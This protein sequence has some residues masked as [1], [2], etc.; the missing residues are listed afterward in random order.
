MI[1][2]ALDH[3][4]NI[5]VPGGTYTISQPI[6]WSS[7]NT[8]LIGAGRTSSIFNFNFVGTAGLL[9][10]TQG[11]TERY[12]CGAEGIQ[13]IDNAGLSRIVDLTDM[14]FCN[15]N[16]CFTYGFGASSSI[17][18]YMG[19]SNVSLQCT[20]NRIQD[21]YNG[22]T[23]YGMYLHDGANANFIDGG[24]FQ[25]ALASAIGIIL[26]PS[27]AALVN[28]NTLLQVGVEQPGNTLT[29]IQLNGN[30][31]GTQ[32]IGPRLE[33]LLNGIVVSSTDTG[34]LLLNPVYSGCTN[35]LVDASNGKAFAGSIPAGA[36]AAQFNYDGTT[37]TTNKAVSCSISRAATGQYQVTGL[38]F[39]NSNF[40][41]NINAN[42]QQCDVAIVSSTTV[43]IFTYNASGV[44]TDAKIYGTFWA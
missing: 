2:N 27:G 3:G 23:Q 30:T 19:S 12:L 14:Q 28:G 21:H 15:F 25:S 37:S 29:G 33:A 8:R 38:P 42:V 41:P 43:N 16:S 32:I 44:A 13:F 40:V 26:A 7:D 39:S 17:G 18:M 5:I 6:E 22:N 24:R 34:V 1:Q 31:V 10:S 20:Y 35:N 4:G 9:S 11:V 36:P